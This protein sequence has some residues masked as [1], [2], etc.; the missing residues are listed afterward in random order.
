MATSN[1]RYNPPSKIPLAFLCGVSAYFTHDGI[2]GL[3]G[4]STA[5]EFSALVFAF[6]SFVA[7]HLFWSSCTNF[8]VNESE[9]PAWKTAVIIGGAIP[10]IIAL[11]SWWNVVSL[12]GDAALDAQLS[13]HTSEM[14]QV[15]TQAF[16]NEKVVS[17]IQDID[18]E[19]IKYQRMGEREKSSGLYSG[20]PGPGAV[21]TLLLETARRLQDLRALSVANQKKHQLLEQQI[22]ALMQKVRTVR[23]EEA[24]RQQT[25]KIGATIDQVNQHLN[26]IN[27]A[28]LI[29]SIARA[30]IDLPRETKLVASLSS[31]QATANN[32]NAAIGKLKLE[33]EHSALKLKNLADTLRGREKVAL[34]QFEA[35]SPQ[36]SVIVYAHQFIPLWLG[37]LALDLAFLVPLLF[38]MI[39]QPRISTLS[40]DEM[41]LEL[42]VGDQL[43]AQRAMTLLRQGA[44]RAPAPQTPGSG[45]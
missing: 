29:Q 8:I 36:L 25:S 22:L 9:Q 13:A 4:T 33:L 39:S 40:D 34:P 38:L 43:R 7:L 45:D 30:A 1:H 28:A 11:S 17:L 19:I 32:Q 14:E 5:G 20:K 31:N 37:G 42:S 6:G 15:V 24:L 12:A 21:H 41:L 26:D 23:A 3:T 35:L 18:L 27:N 2:S 16:E 10:F 44:F